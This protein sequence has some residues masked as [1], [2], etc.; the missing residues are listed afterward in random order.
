MSDGVTLP[1]E[2]ATGLRALL[3]GPTRPGRVVGVFPT[4]VYVTVDDGG[5]STLVAIVTAD[6]VALPCAIVIRQTST[7]VPFRTVVPGS[8]V[9]VGGGAVA[10]SPSLRAHAARWVDRRVRLNETQ[11]DVLARAAYRLETAMH[12]EELGPEDPITPRLAAL[13]DA[14]R[15]RDVSALASAAARLI[16]LGSGLTPTGDDVLAGVLA[17]GR[18]FAAATGDTDLDAL[19]V[20]LWGSIEPTVSDRTTALSA[21]LLRHASRGEMAAPAAALTVALAADRSFAAV[22][23]DLL[24]VGHSS[25]RD[26]A[27]GLLLAARAAAEPTRRTTT[28]PGTR[29]PGV[30]R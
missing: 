18:A 5:C 16:G 12:G 14:L 3:S 26:L 22:L 28:I 29:T 8:Q 20:S 1:G 7:I 9:A 17:G 21:A 30:P 13:S 2:A 24:R 10:L 27:T 23:P 6:G 15:D 11:P 4:A 25:G 19:L